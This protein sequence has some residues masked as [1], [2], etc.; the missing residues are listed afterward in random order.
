MEDK[1]ILRKLSVARAHGGSFVADAAFVVIVMGDPYLSDI[2]IEDAAIASFSMQMQAEDLGIGSCWMQV[3]ER[4]FTDNISTSE[5]IRELLEVPM[6]LQ[7]LSIIAFG[8]K[9]KTR[10][11]HNVDDLLW[12]KVHIEKFNSK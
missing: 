7:V 12:E 4:E 8:K 11:P 6:P 9:A 5:Y 1:E 10:K 2:W 3:R